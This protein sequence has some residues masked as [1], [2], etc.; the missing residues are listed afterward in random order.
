MLV[1]VGGF[2]SLTPCMPCP[3]T[4][5]SSDADIR[6][7]RKERVSHSVSGALVRARLPALLT[8]LLTVR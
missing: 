2:E 3:I 6:M 7:A 4:C 8:P 1:E 5:S